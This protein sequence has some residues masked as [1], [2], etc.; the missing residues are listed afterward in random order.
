MEAD[1]DKVFEES[2]G[3]GSGDKADFHRPEMRQHFI[4]DKCEEMMECS[5]Q[6][7]AAKM[8]YDSENY[9][10]VYFGSDTTGEKAYEEFYVPGE[11]I[12]VQRFAALGVVEQ[13]E[14]HSMDEVDGFFEKLEDI[15]AKENFTKAQV[16]DA[17]REFIPNFGK[18]GFIG[19]VVL[20]HLKING[21]A[22]FHRKTT[23][24]IDPIV[25]FK[26][27]INN[28]KLFW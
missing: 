8:E 21:F 14:R 1:L 23:Q 5:H 17:I 27:N 26:N 2:Y 20:C 3:E 18:S 10:V 7:D 25:S 22:E 15:F 4:F 16:V 13:T 11:K 28:V 24:R 19:K 6:M 9:P 12:D